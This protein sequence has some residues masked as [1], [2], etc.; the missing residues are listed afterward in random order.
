MSVL[1]LEKWETLH[2]T[3]KKWEM[4]CPFVKVSNT[5]CVPIFNEKYILCYFDSFSRELP[6]AE[7]GLWH[8]QTSILLFFVKFCKTLLLVYFH[9]AEGACIWDEVPWVIIVIF[10]ILL[11]IGILGEWLNQMQRQFGNFKLNF[12][13]RFDS[14]FYITLTE[15]IDFSIL[16]NKFHI[17]NLI[18]FILCFPFKS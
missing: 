1:N 4:I 3:N 9:I 5:C 18:K 15:L 13:Y 10:S 17:T 6:F 7:F 11:F 16:P 12:I 14:T 2:L 8:F